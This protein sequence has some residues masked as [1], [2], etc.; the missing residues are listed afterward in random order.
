MKYTD[1][2]SAAS[3]E[4]YRQTEELILEQ[5]NDFVSRDLISIQTGPW[6]FV[7]SSTNDKIEIKRTVRLVLKDKEYIEKL[8]LENSQLKE[9]VREIG[10]LK[11]VIDKI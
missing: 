1:C 10:K 8:E 2:L 3:N 7:Q 9:L 11:E 5:L 6:S 4:I